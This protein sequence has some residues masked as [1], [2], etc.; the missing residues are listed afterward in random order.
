MTEKNSGVK[1]TANRSFRRILILTAF[2]AVLTA[3]AL[4]LHVAAVGG[5]ISGTVKDPTGAIIPG[6]T[7]TG[8]NTAHG[9]ELKAFTDSQGFYT[10]PNL[11]VGKY[12]LTV[13]ANGFKAQK[14]SGLAI[15]VDTA[16][17]VT[18]TL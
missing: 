1:V 18:A 8:K 7:V 9:T 15:D 6:A 14:K 12:D 5:S 13:D 3:I 2:C 4:P 10:F 11:A 17:E 16:L